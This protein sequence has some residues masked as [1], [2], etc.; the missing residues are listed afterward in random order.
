MECGY[1]PIQGKVF[2]E[3]QFLAFL[4]KTKGKNITHLTEANYPNSIGFIL[5]WI[6]KPVKN[7]HQ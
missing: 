2:K 3:Q 1:F 7:R 5:L 6:E 4:L